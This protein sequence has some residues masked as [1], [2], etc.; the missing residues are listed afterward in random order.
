MFRYIPPCEKP[1][2]VRSLK[3][4]RLYRRTHSQKDLHWL[5]AIPTPKVRCSNGRVHWMYGLAIPHRRPS[6]RPGG[7]KACGSP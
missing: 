2:L 3:T 1:R 7:I 4:Q 6:C 5:V